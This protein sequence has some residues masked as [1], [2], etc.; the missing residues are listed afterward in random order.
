MSPHASGEGVVWHLA[1]AE[2]WERARR[3]GEYRHSTLGRT[4]EEEGFIH[5][6]RDHA[7]LAGVVRRFYRG[8]TEPLVLLEVDTGLLGCPVR[9]EPPGAAETFPHIYGPIPARAVRSAVPYTPPEE[10]GL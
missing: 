2:H 3:S 7:Q 8:V 6:S 4:L 5:A 10:G 9:Y 1:L